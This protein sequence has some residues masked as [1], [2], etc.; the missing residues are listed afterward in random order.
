MILKDLLDVIDKDRSSIHEIIRIVDDEKGDLCAPITNPIWE[1]L[2]DR[3]VGALYAAGP[4]QYDVYL[5]GGS[6]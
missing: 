5:K 4:G 1:K 3:E 2:E 6:R